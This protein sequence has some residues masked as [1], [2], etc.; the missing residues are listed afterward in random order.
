MGFVTSRRVDTEA[1]LVTGGLVVPVPVALYVITDDLAST[2]VL[3]LTGFGGDR[4]ISFLFC[5]TIVEDDVGSTNGVNAASPLNI[6]RVTRIFG[7]GILEGLFKFDTGL[8]LLFGLVFSI[9]AP[10]IPWVENKE[11]IRLNDAV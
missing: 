7:A 9:N 5:P 1:G 10:I 3:V 8:L 4:S 6:E 11:K 2:V